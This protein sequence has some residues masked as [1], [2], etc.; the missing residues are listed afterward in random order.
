MRS[1]AWAFIALFKLPLFPVHLMPSDFTSSSGNSSPSVILSTGRGGNRQR[2]ALSMLQNVHIILR[3]GRNTAPWETSLTLQ[4]RQHH[5]FAWWT[6]ACWQP[7]V[8]CAIPSLLL[9][10]P[11]T[12]CEGCHFCII[13]ATTLTFASVT[14]A[15]ILAP[16]LTS[17]Y[18]QRQYYH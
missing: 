5:I 6:A 16:I 3:L 2:F 9:P 10:L 15:S 13:L 17:W 11:H 14:V 18:Y 1:L 4:M 12:S 8:I 7:P